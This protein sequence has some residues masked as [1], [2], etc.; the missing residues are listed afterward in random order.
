MTLG[1]CWNRERQGHANDTLAGR[2]LPLTSVPASAPARAASSARG[3][4]GDSVD[5]P[6]TASHCRAPHEPLLPWN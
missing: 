1:G 5:S 3:R 2:L 6:S 4:L